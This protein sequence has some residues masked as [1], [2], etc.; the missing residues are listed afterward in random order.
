MRLRN[1]LNPC[2]IYGLWRWTVLV[3]VNHFKVS[4]NLPSF[5]FNTSKWFYPDDN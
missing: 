4:A 3:R 5:T 1:L 2:R